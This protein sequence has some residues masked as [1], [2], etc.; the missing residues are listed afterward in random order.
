MINKI[1]KPYTEKLLS[2]KETAKCWYCKLPTQYALNEKDGSEVWC[3]E[4]HLWKIGKLKR[5]KRRMEK[6]STLKKKCENSKN[7]CVKNQE[8]GYHGRRLE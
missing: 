3:C 6:Y 2:G 7:L 4:Y 8:D 5:F 1:S